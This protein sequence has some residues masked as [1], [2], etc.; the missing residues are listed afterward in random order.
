MAPIVT[1]LD[2]IPTNLSSVR[3]ASIKYLLNVRVG[4]HIHS[5]LKFFVKKSWGREP[6]LIF[7][8]YSVQKFVTR[9]PTVHRV[10]E[11][12]HA[13]DDYFLILASN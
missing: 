13:R 9:V 4:N 10:N 11:V 1:K 8:Q 12:I 2:A 5:L 7:E 3:V 6:N